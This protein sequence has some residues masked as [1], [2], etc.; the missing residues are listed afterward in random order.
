V[1]REDQVLSISVAARA[2]EFEL[3]RSQ[4][5][6]QRPVG[7]FRRNRGW[8]IP[9]CGFTA[10]CIAGSV[11]GRT[12]VSALLSAGLV[13]IRLQPVVSRFLKFG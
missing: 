6:G 8:I 11:A 9:L 12:T 4:R 13:A 5:L 3:Q 10:G 7:T 1:A 2:V